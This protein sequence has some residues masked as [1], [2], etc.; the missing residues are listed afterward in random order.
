MH[1]L[2]TTE[3]I[4]KYHSSYYTGPAAK[5]GA[6][7]VAGNV[8]STVSDAGYRILGGT[9]PSVGLAGGYTSGGG[10]SLLNGLY[11]MAA[12]AVLEW[13]V[14]TAAGKHLI[15]SPTSN[16]DLY[17]ALTGGGAGNLAVVL[18]MT[19]KIFPEGPI[20]SAA[21]VI[22]STDPNYW[23]A[24]ED[25]WAFLPAFVDEG[26]N[27][28]DFVMASTG[29]SS[30]GLTA[31]NKTA[32]E[33]R[34][35]LHPFLTTLNTHNIDYTFTPQSYPTYHAYFTTQ[36]GQG[37]NVDPANIQLTSRLIPRSAVQ[38][39]TQTR[40]I[41]SAMKAFTDAEY[42]EVGCHALNVADTPRTA[43]NA[44]YS[45]W[46]E[47]IANC[48]IVSFWDWDVE[49][50]EMEK[51][52]ELLVGTLIPGLEAATPTSGSY[53]N[54]IDAQY[55]GDWK[56]E[57]YAENYERLL[58]LKEEYDPGHLFYAKFAVGSDYYTVDEV[59]R[60]CAA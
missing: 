16:A 21:L 30:L 52:K 31:P 43:P 10:H 17:W 42:W 54:E 25:L 60:L 6:G 8:Y 32:A 27:T 13:E 2:N 55:R 5:L 29:F 51:R 20:G 37:L 49:W 48:N 57:L 7:V 40:T 34:T 44:V 3:I 39:T 26:P 22:N 24:M 14:I 15:A 18:S 46:R 36:I 58:S 47:A 12:D 38:N 23:Q 56:R 53:L 9:C 19:T 50:T 4:P 33:V 59:G 28:W 35:L 45:K 41:L 11:G 1:N